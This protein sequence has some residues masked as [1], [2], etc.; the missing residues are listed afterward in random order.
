MVWRWFLGFLA[1]LERPEY[2]EQIRFGV[3]RGYRHPFGSGLHLL[4]LGLGGNRS[5]PGATTVSSRWREAARRLRRADAL[6]GG[7]LNRRGSAGPDL[8]SHS[9]GQQLHLRRSRLDTGTARLDRGSHVRAFEY[10]GA[11][12]ERL[13][14]DNLRSAVTRP[15]RYEPQP[16]AT[17]QE[18]AHLYNTAILPA[19][20]V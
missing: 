6:G 20:T 3:R 19:R 13:V 9:V 10:F 7:A 17:Y 4:G 14:P 5:G 12:P 18:I 16:N 15:C 8:C 11:V 2:L 1:I